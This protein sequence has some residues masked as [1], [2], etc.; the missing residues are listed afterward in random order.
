MLADISHRRGAGYGAAILGVAVV[1]A[2]FAPLH[3]TLNTTTVALAYLLVVLFVATMWG[4][5][6]AMVASVLAVLCFN[7]FFLPPIYT[8][9]V[10]DPQNW[11]ALAAFLITAVTAG[12]LSELA[13]RRAAEAEAGRSAL[14]RSADEI[15]DLYNHAPCGY[16]SLDK[17]GV[18]VRINDT[19]LEWLGYPREDVIGKVKFPDLLAPRSRGTFEAKFPRLKTE[20]VVRDSEFDLVRKDGTILPVLISATA[21]TDPDGN[22]LMS[23]STVYDMTERKRA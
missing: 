18:F 7:F 11:V 6:P 2:I 3:S 23:R 22:Y 10:T 13:R 15:R 20:G 16:H 17:D 5:S 1:T 12:Q 9:T 8:F 14:Q 19:E 21:I 4:R